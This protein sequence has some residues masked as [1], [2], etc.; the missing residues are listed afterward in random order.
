MK[1]V[2]AYKKA[3]PVAASGRNELPRL[4]AAMDS[5]TILQDAPY[6]VEHL[7]LE[8]GKIPAFA[9]DAGR[10]AYMPANEAGPP[11]FEGTPEDYFEMSAEDKR[12]VMRF[13]NQ[14]LRSGIL[15]PFKVL[16]ADD[17]TAILSRARAMEGT[18]KN[19]PA[20]GERVAAT[21]CVILKDTV[22]CDVDGVPATIPSGEVFYGS[23]PPFRVLEVGKTYRAQVLQDCGNYLEI[24]TKREAED[25]WQNLRYKKKNVYKGEVIRQAKTT[26]DSEGHEIRGYVIELEAGVTVYGRCSPFTEY[27]VGDTV[28]VLITGIDE[29]NRRMGGRIVM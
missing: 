20:E 28:S 12:R 24:S 7:D 4:K 19:K 15:L 23:V 1:S 2:N 5:N 13:M 17:Y 3:E 14:Y 18:L 29:E 11:I 25:P 22:W 27:Q 8:G 6:A 16:E 9:F 21:V 26:F 10:P